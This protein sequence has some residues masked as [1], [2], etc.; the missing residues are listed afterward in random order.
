MIE[1]WR[2]LHW[3]MAETPALCISGA[4]KIC[5]DI[6]FEI[7]GEDFHTELTFEDLGY[8]TKGKLGQLKRNYWN[9]ALVDKAIEKLLSRKDKGHCSAAIKM[10]A[11]EKDSR[12]S[13]FCI[14]NMVI[15]ICE[16]KSFIDL[17]Y[18]STE[19]SMKFLDDLLFLCHVLPPVFQ[20]LGIF[21]QV[22]R[23]K[24]A[25]AFISALYQPVFLRFEEDPVGFYKH[26]EKNDPRFYRTC[27]LTTSKY[28]M[29]T[30]SYTYRMRI[31][32]FEYFQHWVTKEKI[33]LL[34]PVFKGLR[35][36]IIEEEEDDD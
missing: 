30:H 35:P 24:F 8:T 6:Q 33:D 7:P 26:L 14:Q 21:P 27:S 18:R 28:L 25:N 3:T 22:I 36:D 5:G 10:E 20:T 29:E 2:R 17:Y 15:T 11:G 23:F 1:H 34:R 19:I 13:G 32:M 9:Q 16:G 4:R 12:S 31:R